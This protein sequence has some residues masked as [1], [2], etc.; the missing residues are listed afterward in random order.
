MTPPAHE[1]LTC[2]RQADASKGTQP[3]DFARFGAFAATAA[4]AA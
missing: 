2:F 3:T 1:R 4:R